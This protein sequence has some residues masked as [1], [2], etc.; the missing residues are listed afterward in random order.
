MRSPWLSVII[1]TYNGRRFLR[2]ALESIVIQGSDDIEVVAVDD[3]STDDT[4]SI[5]RSYEDRLALRIVEQERVGNWVAG[6][7]RGLRVASGKYVSLLHQDDIWLPG[8]ISFLREELARAGPAALVIHPV[9]FIDGRGRRV[10]RWRC[11]LP[12]DVLL[13]DDVVIERLLVQNFVSVAGTLFPRASALDV[14]GMDEGLWYTA[15]WD[16]WLKMAGLGD[17]LHVPR[18]LA[19]FRVHP[20]AMTMTRSIRLDDFRQQ[21]ELVLARHLGP[22]KVERS[23]KASVEAAARLSVEANV[24][25]ASLA[26]RRLP[27]MGS[28]F[29]AASSLGPVDWARYLRDSR[30]VERAGAR[31][32]AGIGT[33]RRNR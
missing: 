19:G 11:P 15:D 33:R 7:N 13:P 32:R 22:W 3:G 2:Q 24:A 27:A 4:L 31:V 1:P 25:M 10:G 28:L 12:P 6:T 30:L 14:G 8:R 18:M 16:L 9:V 5:L 26:H 29:R 21:L 23:R 20:L 17:S